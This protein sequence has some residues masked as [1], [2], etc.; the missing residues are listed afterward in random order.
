MSSQS[1]KDDLVEQAQAADK[2]IEQFE[3]EL[4]ALA[5]KRKKISAEL[6]IEKRQMAAICTIMEKLY[7]EYVERDALL[8][9]LRIKCCK[10][11]I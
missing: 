1:F 6:H 5:E 9:R 7:P 8:G 10:A 2:R 11:H 4:S 3:N